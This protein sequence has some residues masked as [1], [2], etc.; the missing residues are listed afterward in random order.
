M[1][2]SDSSLSVQVSQIT[3]LKSVSFGKCSYFHMATENERASGCNG[4]V[5]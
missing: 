4:N 1:F 2:Y 3:L 5:S